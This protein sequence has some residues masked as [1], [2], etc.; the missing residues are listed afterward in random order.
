[1]H[2]KSERSPDSVRRYPVT[3]DTPRSYIGSVVYVNA[4]TPTCMPRYSLYFGYSFSTSRSHRGNTEVTTHN[5]REK[6]P[7]SCDLCWVTHKSRALH[8]RLPP[9]SSPARIHHTAKRA[10]WALFSGA[11]DRVSPKPQST[12]RCVGTYPSPAAILES[13]TPGFPTWMAAGTYSLGSVLHR[14]CLA[15]S[16]RQRFVRPLPFSL[17][18][19]RISLWTAHTAQPRSAMDWNFGPVELPPVRGPLFTGQLRST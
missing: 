1:M 12:I 4:S 6:C 15:A 16:H 8:P 17:P 2:S 13:H 5:N 10:S 9:R 19:C 18:V 3:P 7:N 14:A 11:S